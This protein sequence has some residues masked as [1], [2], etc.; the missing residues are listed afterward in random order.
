MAVLLLSVCLMRV[1]GSFSRSSDT[2]TEPDVFCFASASTKLDPYPKLVDTR[3]QMQARPDLSKEWNVYRF[4]RARWFK[5]LRQCNAC[6][7]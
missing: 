2:D 7:C 1:V 6:D 4:S 3:L 5:G